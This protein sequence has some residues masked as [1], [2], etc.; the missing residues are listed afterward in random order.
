MVYLLHFSKPISSNHTCQH[1]L[2]Y[3]EDVEARLSDHKAGYG[4]RLTQVANELGIDY[5]VVRTWEGDR[6]KERKLKN[7]KNSPKLC[8]I[9]NQKITE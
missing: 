2:G 3:A 7:L 9:C 6:K 5:E 1:Y 4:A 8:P